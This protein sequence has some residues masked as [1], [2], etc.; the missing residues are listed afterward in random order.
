ML[1]A[2]PCAEHLHAAVKLDRCLDNAMARFGP[3]ARPGV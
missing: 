3:A 1:G 2:E